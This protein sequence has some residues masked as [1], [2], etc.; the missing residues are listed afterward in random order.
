MSQ[1]NKVMLLEDTKSIRD[2]WYCCPPQPTKVYLCIA[3]CHDVDSRTDF[4][5]CQTVRVTHATRLPHWRRGATMSE[6]RLLAVDGNREWRSR[7]RGCKS[8]T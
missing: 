3:Q 4:P 1:D 7:L 8:I 2:A 5:G 6:R